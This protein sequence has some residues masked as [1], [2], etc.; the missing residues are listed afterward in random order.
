MQARL[1]PSQNGTD[2]HRMYKLLIF[3][4]PHLERWAPE[5]LEQRRKRLERF[6]SSAEQS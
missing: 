1:E 5:V 2:L 6:D 4:E 3:V